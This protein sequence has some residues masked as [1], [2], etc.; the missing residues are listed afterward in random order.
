[1][2]KSCPQ[3]FIWEIEAPGDGL[4]MLHNN[5]KLNADKF[6]LLVISSSR[7]PRPTLNSICIDNNNVP[8]A[9][10]A[11]N[12]GVVFDEVMSLLP[13]VTNIC[14]TACFHLRAIL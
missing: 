4:P 8:A 9:P 1:M 5:L 13:H 12:I 6:E 10:S 11:K 3:G 2:G 7:R 14:K